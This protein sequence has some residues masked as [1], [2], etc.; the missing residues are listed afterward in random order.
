MKLLLTA[1]LLAWGLTAMASEL[2][3]N[4]PVTVSATSEQL[5]QRTYVPSQEKPQGEVRLIQREETTVVQTL[6]YSKVLKRVVG[7]ICKKEQQHWPQQRQGHEGAMRYVASLRQALDEIGQRFKA[8]T[9]RDDRR[10][11]L[12]IE[13]SLSDRIALVAFFEPTIEEAEG[14]VRVLDKRPIAI[15]EASRAYVA[16][17]MLEIIQDAFALNET[18]AAAMLLNP[19]PRDLADK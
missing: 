6:L 2:V 14:K 13:F 10:Q 3:E 17:N 7:A 16:G 15:W 8:R 5:L 12:L 11:K 9:D 4:N 19:N 1:A 18:Q